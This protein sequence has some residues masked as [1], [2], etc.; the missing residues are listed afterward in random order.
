NPLDPLD[1]ETMLQGGNWDVPSQTPYKVFE[2]GGVGSN[3][4]HQLFC[5]D[6]TSLTAK[7]DLARCLNLPGVFYWALDY[8]RHDYSFWSVVA[9]RLSSPGMVDPPDPDHDGLGDT[10]DNCPNAA[11]PFQEDSDCDGVGDACD[12]C[13]TVANPDQA[14][15]DGDGTG[16]LCDL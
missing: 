16:N 12:N 1:C 8:V 13:P 9:P 14:D 10:C 15:C 7:L 2:K 3:D 5:E 4:W 6:E 11:N